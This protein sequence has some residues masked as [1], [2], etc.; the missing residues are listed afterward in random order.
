[1]GHG[2]CDS[3]SKSTTCSNYITDASVIYREIKKIYEKCNVDFGELRGLGIQ[4]TKLEKIAII[5][6]ALNKFLQQES[7]PKEGV[8]ATPTDKPVTATLRDKP[9]RGRPK[10]SKSKPERKNKASIDNFFKTTKDGTSSKSIKVCFR[11]ILQLFLF[12]W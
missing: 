11:V 1:M 3:L 8:E 7:K 12:C 9:G 4:L 5:N 2:I 10:A 6:P